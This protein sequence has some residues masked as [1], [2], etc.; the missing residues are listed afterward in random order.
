ML[1]TTQLEHASRCGEHQTLESSGGCAGCSNYK[2]RYELNGGCQTSI[3]EIATIAVQLKAL[4]E[5]TMFE[6]KMN[7]SITGE[8]VIS[9]EMK[10]NI[11]D[12]LNSFVDR[13]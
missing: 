13:V 10:K 1:T 7:E 9:D 2:S 4:L 3:K 11:N 6:I 12:A 8:K 5:N